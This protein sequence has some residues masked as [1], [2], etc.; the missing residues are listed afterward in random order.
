MF[1][2][3][4]KKIVKRIYLV[5]DNGL[6]DRKAFYIVKIGFYS[7]SMNVGQFISYKLQSSSVLMILSFCLLEMKLKK[8][9]SCVV[10]KLTL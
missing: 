6:F 4:R 2:K 7:S 10:H 9:I 1:D 3:K 8:F 5:T